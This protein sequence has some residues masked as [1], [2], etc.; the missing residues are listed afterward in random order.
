MLKAEDSSKLGW[1]GEHSGLSEE[2]NRIT[3]DVL[4]VLWIIG[5]SIQAVPEEFPL[6]LSVSIVFSILA[7]RNLPFLLRTPQKTYK[8]IRQYILDERTKVRVLNL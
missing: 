4:E 6:R 7:Q 5:S 8:I 3:D 1:T 2:K